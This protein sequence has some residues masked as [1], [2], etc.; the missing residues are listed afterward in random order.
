MAWVEMAFNR[1]SFHYFEAITEKL[2]LLE[3]GTNIALLIFFKWDLV[4]FLELSK[5]QECKGWKLIAILEHF[6]FITY[7]IIGKQRDSAS[8]KYKVIKIKP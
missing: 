8:L 4:V 3:V 5:D 7:K 1:I 6:L 2:I